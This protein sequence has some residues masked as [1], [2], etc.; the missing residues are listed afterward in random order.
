MQRALKLIRVENSI[1]VVIPDDLLEYLG[2][3]AGDHLNW[4]E[5]SEG[6]ELRAADD[7]QDSQMQTARDVMTHRRRAL[8]LLAK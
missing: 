7:N 2:V 3:R 8:H 4:A 5:T 6:I 1:G